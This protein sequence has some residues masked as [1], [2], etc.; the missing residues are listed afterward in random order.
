VQ[1]TMRRKIIKIGTRHVGFVMLAQDSGGVGEKCLN[2]REG[3]NC[4]YFTASLGTE[5]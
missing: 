4:K 5:V 3:V 1:S 2:G